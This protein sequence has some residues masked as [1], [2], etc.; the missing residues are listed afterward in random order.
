[1]Q[2]L[3]VL[4]QIHASAH[5]D[6]VNKLETGAPLS[7]FY[8]LH[9]IIAKKENSYGHDYTEMFCQTFFSNKQ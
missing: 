8:L 9:I 3:F 2:L 4:L 6:M 1:M 7:H 5:A